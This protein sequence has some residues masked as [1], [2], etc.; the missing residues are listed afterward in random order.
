MNAL[1][2]SIPLCPT[3]D[4][5]LSGRGGRVLSSA[6][7]AKVCQLLPEEELARQVNLSLMITGVVRARSV[8]QRKIAGEVPFA[9]Q[10]TGLMQRQR[11]FLKNRHVDVEAYY[12]PFI[13]P[14]VQAR[15]QRG[16]PLIIDSSPAG[17]YCQMLVASIGYIRRLIDCL[18]KGEGVSFFQYK[19]LH[20]VSNNFSNY[21]PASCLDTRSL[22]WLQYLFKEQR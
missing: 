6:I 2:I 22:R 13:T 1:H 21:R 15:G 17:R 4:C 18:V 8:Q 14:F 19:W 10:V 20:N 5:K 12:R 7:K 3:Y 16:M 9:A 11:R